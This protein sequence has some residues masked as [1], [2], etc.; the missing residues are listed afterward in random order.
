MRILARA[1]YPFLPFEASH[2]R[3]TQPPAHLPQLAQGEEAAAA[4]VAEQ[5]AEAARL[6]ALW[7]NVSNKVELLWSEGLGAEVKG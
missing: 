5:E 6:A 1:H 2:S 4:W 3:V 7:A